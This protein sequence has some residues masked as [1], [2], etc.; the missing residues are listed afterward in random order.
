A[1]VLATGVSAQQAPP[2]FKY[3]RPI[4]TGGPGPRRLAIDVT[5]LA[6]ANPF[7][8]VSRT[9]NPTTGEVSATAAGGLS[10]MR[11]FDAGGK[12]IAYLLVPPPVSEPEWIQAH[13]L[14]IAPN[15]T[16]TEKTSGFEADLGEPR[17]IDRFRISGLN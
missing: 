4:V 8:V 1:L 3:E 13:I 15:E 16:K 17:P 9:I 2:A 11:L 7:R 14:P 12:E 10:D 6:G 5:L